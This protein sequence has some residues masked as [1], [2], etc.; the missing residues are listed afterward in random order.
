MNLENLLF[1][2]TDSVANEVMDSASHVK[3]HKSVSTDMLSNILWIDRKTAERT[4]EVTAQRFCRSD[5]P[6]PSRNYPANDRTLRCD[7][8]DELFFVDTFFSA[9]REKK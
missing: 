3:D 8:I 9:K 6:S 1:E 2:H 5:A 7:L 4:L